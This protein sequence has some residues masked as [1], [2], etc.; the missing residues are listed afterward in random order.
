MAILG[1]GKKKTVKKPAKAEKKATS[2]AQIKVS[3]T[4]MI[5]RPRI[6]EKAGIAAESKNIYTFEVA[7]KATKPGVKAAIIA[8][9]NVTPVKV[10]IINLASRDAV[11]RGR[12]STLAGY[13]KALVFL[14]KGDKIEFV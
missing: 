7:A 6:T 4:D 8:L 3:T 12:K 10:N 9:Y 13:K 1:I 5:I 14:K 2:L 11:I